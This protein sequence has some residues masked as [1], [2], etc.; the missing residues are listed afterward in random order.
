MHLCS[1][2]IYTLFI[3]THVIGAYIRIYMSTRH[4]FLHVYS[5]H[6]HIPSLI[7]TSTA[8]MH[9]DPCNQSSQQEPA[10]KLV[11]KGIFVHSSRLHN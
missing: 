6:I 3:H 8:C 4:T 10:Y 5:T 1:S 7:Y 9:L 2:N 11:T